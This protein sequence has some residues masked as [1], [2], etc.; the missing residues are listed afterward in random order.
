MSGAIWLVSYPRSGNTWTRM[1]LYSLR[2]DGGEVD[3]EDVGLFGRMAARRERID[4]A[5]EVD[6]GL[7]TQAELE[8]LRPDAHAVLYGA[9][10]EPELSKV[11]DAWIRTPSGRPVF[12]AAFTHATI[13]LIRDP[14]DVAVSW[15]R[16]VRWPIDR[17]I[18]FLCDHDAVL[19]TSVGGIGTQ[20]PQPVGSWSDHA[21]S[22]IDESGLDPLV[23]RYE[24]MLADP[25]ES[26][27]AMAE[28]VGWEAPAGA[29]ARAVEITR[30]DQLAAKEQREGFMERAPRAERFFHSGKSG[31]WRS[32]LTPAQA[33][34]I[35]RENR[36]MMA[37]FGYL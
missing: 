29:V 27:R 31:T 21:R 30:F 15:A 10:H 6:S 19:G 36:E 5:L 20:I 22:W 25:G 33:G 4:R 37:R 16:F 14:R 12:D 17:S 3:F 24:D 32:L 9:M 11:H 35:E 26:L 23:M 1:A 13:Y 2:G 18:A 28:H 8:E 7:L 34:V